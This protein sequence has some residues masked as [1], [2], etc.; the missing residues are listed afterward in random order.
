MTQNSLIT[1]EDVNRRL[2]LVRVIVRDAVELKADILSRQDRLSELRDHRPESDHD[3]SPYADEVLQME[4]SIE[5]DEIRIDGF[6]EELLRIG[7]QLVD[8]ES[9]LV[10]FVSTL[11]SEEILLSWMYDEEEV[12]HWRAGDESPSERKPLMLTGQKTA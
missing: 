11:G 7:G 10:E 9:G 6:A 3:H 4:E 2:P 5:N 8:A 12:T 1:L